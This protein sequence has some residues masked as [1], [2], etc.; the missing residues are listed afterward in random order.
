MGG[1]HLSSVNILLKSRLIYTNKLKYLFTFLLF[2]VPGAPL[3]TY[4]GYHLSYEVK[5]LM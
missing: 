1:K 2:S 4:G 3:E 5:K